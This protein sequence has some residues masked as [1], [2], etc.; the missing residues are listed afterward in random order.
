MATVIRDITERKRA[1]EKLRESEAEYRSLF[2]DS[3]L[4]ISQA[5][6]DGHSI[7]ANMT[8]AHMYGYSTPDQMIREV[9]DFGQFYVHPEERK[10]VLRII[11][12]KG[13]MEPRE[14]QLV[15]RD[16]TPFTALVS[17]RAVK[18]PNGKL[19]YYQATHI[20]ITEL[21]RT[22]QARREAESLLRTVLNSAPITIFATDSQG[23]F[24]LSEGKGLEHAGL[25]P[26]ENVGVSAVDL[27]DSME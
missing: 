19:L 27:Y 20:D 22:E 2:E 21:K 6:P 10:D 4:A 12:E 16:G 17:A 1:E 8:Y 11:N 13:F 25:K 24:T 7:R 15:R 23:K 9:S 14:F 18:D 26:S 3:I 5:T